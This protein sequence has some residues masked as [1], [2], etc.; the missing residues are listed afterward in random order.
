MSRTTSSRNTRTRYFQWRKSRG[1]L[2][3]FHGAVVDHEGSE[4]TREFKEVAEVGRALAKRDAVIGAS[5]K[6]ETVYSIRFM[7]KRQWRAPM[8]GSSCLVPG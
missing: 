3:K 2:E 6:R 4:H 1:G 8:V 5:A 7:T